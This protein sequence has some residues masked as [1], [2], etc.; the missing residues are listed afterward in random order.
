MRLSA[1]IAASSVVVR[2]K[3]T[4]ISRTFSVLGEKKNNGIINGQS[5][6]MNGS[7]QSSDIV[8]SAAATTHWKRSHYQNIENKFHNTKADDDAPTNE[9]SSNTNRKQQEPLNITNDDDVQPMWK[10]MESRVT[11]RRSLTLQQLQQRGGVSGRRNMRKSD[12]DVWLEAG[13]YTT[14]DDTDTDNDV[15]DKDD[16]DKDKKR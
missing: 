15:G 7:S 9:L 11:K 5:S 4:T 14:S 3:T 16:D 2:R 13:V 8:E 12:E 6:T 1:T 10:E